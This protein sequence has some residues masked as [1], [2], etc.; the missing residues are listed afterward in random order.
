MSAGAGSPIE[1]LRA[2]LRVAERRPDAAG[3]IRWS[4]HAEGHDARLEAKFERQRG[5]R[6]RVHTRRLRAEG[7]SFHVWLVVVWGRGE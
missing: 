6:A 7:R 4:V 1:E 3:P 5:H 2:K